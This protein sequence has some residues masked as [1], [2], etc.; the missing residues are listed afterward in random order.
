M[1]MLD[2]IQ[3]KTFKNIDQSAS[4]KEKSSGVRNKEGM[5]RGVMAQGGIRYGRWIWTLTTGAEVLMPKKG[6]GD[7]ACMGGELARTMRKDLFETE[8]R[9]TL[10]GARKC[11]ICQSW[12]DKVTN[13]KLESKTVTMQIY[14]RSKFTLL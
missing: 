3:S 5:N 14:G 4:R 9:K 1:E 8:T 11:S 10:T 6:K 2:K 12:V 13:E 7:D